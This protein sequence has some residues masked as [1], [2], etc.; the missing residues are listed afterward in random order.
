MSWMNLI[1]NT[2]W[3]GNSF[4]P[5]QATDIAQQVD[6]LYSFLLWTSGIACAM[7]I[8]GMAYF[9]IKYKRKTNND[10]TAYISHNT[11]AEFLW[12][13]IP[14]VIFLAVFGWG[15][16]IFH[17]M[18]NFPENA[19]EIHVNGKQWA[20]DFTYK[21]GKKS[22]NEFYVPVNT[23]V[24]LIMTSEDVI[25]SFYIPSMRIKT[26]VVPGRYTAQW[27][28]AEKLGDY[29]VFCTEY[30]GAAHSAMAAT[31]HVVSQ[32]DYEKWLQENEEGLTL[33]QKGKKY[34]NDKGC[35]ACHSIDGSVR[36]G[37][38]WKGL[39]GK[40]E[41]WEEGHGIADENYLRESILNPNAKIV[42]G[43]PKG[44]MPPYQ[45]QLSEN[46]V[47]ALIEYIKELK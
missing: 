26:D 44:V 35:A 46:D 30:C 38:T 45:G 21:S 32:E 16:H 27:F 12:S 34:Y 36:V 29:H 20:W 8:G 5:T 14:L 3:A 37:P 11:L 1:T 40:D 6:S 31:L 4:M 33:A 43:Y 28:N 39:F 9:A 17:Q 22:G 10:K 2:A 19:L 42:K 7:I 18:R 13:F 47:T 23:P 24:K 41:V 25:H 15:W